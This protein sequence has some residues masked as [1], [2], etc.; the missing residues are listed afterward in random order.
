MTCP[1]ATA[2]NQRSTMTLEEAL[3][4]VE[5]A[6]DKGCLNNVQELVFR[7]SWEGQSYDDI[8]EASSYDLATSKMSALNCGSRFH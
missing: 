3:E 7:Q 8:A 2:Q 4:L 6:L 1:I 5:Q